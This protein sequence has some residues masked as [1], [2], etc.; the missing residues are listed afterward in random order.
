MKKFI[1]FGALV[2]L[3]NGAGGFCACNIDTLGACK[4]N[5]KADIGSGINESLQDKILPNRLNQQIQP[6]NTFNNRTNL[7]QKHL[8]DNINME[9]SQEGNSKPY[10]ANCQFGNCIN[11]GDVDKE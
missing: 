9:P 11:R 5:I 4:A 1:I 6:N 7:G 3:F 8:P 2:L 10:D